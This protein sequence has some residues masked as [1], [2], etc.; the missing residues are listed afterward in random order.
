MTVDA[1]T[2]ARLID[3]VAQQIAALGRQLAAT[4]QSRL[5]I[6]RPDPQQWAGPTSYFFHLACEPIG[7]EL[8]QSIDHLQ[9]A[10]LE[11]RRL[12]TNLAQS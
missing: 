2:R 8:L 10:L 1:A 12:L 3:T 7:A 5:L 4:E 6:P 9:R 11:S